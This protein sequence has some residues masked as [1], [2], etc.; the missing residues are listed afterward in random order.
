MSGQRNQSIN[1]GDSRHFV[2][3]RGVTVGSMER[4]RRC[5]S[6]R[7]NAAVAKRFRAPRGARTLHGVEKAENAYFFDPSALNCFK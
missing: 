7:L 4:A 2:A 6:A 1:D 5:M 3:E